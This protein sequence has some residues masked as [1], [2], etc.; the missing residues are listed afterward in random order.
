MRF[1]E[2]PPCCERSFQCRDAVVKPVVED[3]MD[4]DRIPVESGAEVTPVPPEPS[5]SEKMKSSLTH[6]FNHGARHA[7]KVKRKPSHTSEQSASSKT[8]NSHLCNGTRKMLRPL[9]D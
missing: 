4:D 7:S 8:A 5:E 3:P 6:H 1:V 2:S 9:T